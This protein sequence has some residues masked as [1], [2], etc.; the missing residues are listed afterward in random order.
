MQNIQPVNKHVLRLTLG[1]YLLFL[2]LGLDT[3][4]AGP[5][6][7]ALAQQTQSRL[8]QIG[9]LFLFGAVGYTV[10]T[11]FGGRIFDR[12]P[13][14]QI[15]GAAQIVAALLIAS[16]PFLPILWLLI[17]IYILKGFFEGIIN[18]GTN[19]L[20]TWTHGLKVSPY[21]NGLHFCFGLGAFIAPLLAAQFTSVVG[22]YRW[23]FWII[24]ALA[25]LA[26]LIV[27][28]MPGSPEPSSHQ[29]HEPS[30]VQG[31]LRQDFVFIMTAVIFLFFYVGAE[32]T[33]GGWIYTYAFTLNLA[34]AAQAAYLTSGFW[35]SFTI[36][37]LLSIPI[38]TRL[39]PRYSIVVALIGCLGFITLPVFIPKSPEILWVTT[40]G[41][42]FFMAPIW[43]SG[44]TLAGQSIQLTAR[45]SGII[46]LGDSI[47]GMVLPTVVGQVI[48]SIGP[49]A[50][51][52][53]V[54]SSLIG[55]LLG[56]F[57]MLRLKP[58]SR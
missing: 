31:R 28:F 33:Y 9:F 53:L 45:S 48:E 27:L 17:L 5:N 30:R 40:L 18:T 16:I 50:L 24:A 11:A 8:G 51:I 1:Y 56:F 25:A 19:T 3:A 44:F 42:G 34:T 32:I 23:A 58:K 38:A 41:L 57:G 20:L 7:P 13:G 26:G 12:L 21:M 29:V 52:I 36:G 49:R 47:G 4:L 15:M 35:L 14:H 54:F 55:T 43:P 2:V 37:R 22:G 46:L 6:L 10:G 39:K